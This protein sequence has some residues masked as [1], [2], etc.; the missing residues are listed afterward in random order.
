LQRNAE[1]EQNSL[2]MQLEQE[3]ARNKELMQSAEVVKKEPQPTTRTSRKDKP[4]PA[5][6]VAQKPA[7]QVSQEKYAK[8]DQNPKPNATEKSSK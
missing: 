1:A 6:D 3:Q 8:T 4:S 7:M 2:R 5:I